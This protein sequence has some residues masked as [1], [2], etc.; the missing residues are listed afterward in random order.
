[1]KIIFSYGLFIASISLFFIYIFIF[2][3]FEIAEI[4]YFIF[5]EKYFW[6]SFAHIQAIK[7]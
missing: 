3:F 7:K 2:I 1:M 5:Y 4:F 6:V